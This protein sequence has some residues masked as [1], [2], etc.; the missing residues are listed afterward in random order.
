MGE[1]DLDEN[2]KGELSEAREVLGARPMALEE[3]LGMDGVEERMPDSGE[4]AYYFY[5]FTPYYS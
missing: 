4:S 3:I 5:V 2:G 1:N